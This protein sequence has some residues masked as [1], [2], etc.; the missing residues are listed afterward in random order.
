RN[1][2]PLYEPPPQS[3]Q[4][5]M[6]K[7]MG[8]EAS[9]LEEVICQWTEDLGSLLNQHKSFKAR[10]SGLVASG[11]S[12]GVLKV[13]IG[14]TDGVVDGTL[15]ATLNANAA[16]YA[17]RTAEGSAIATPAAGATLIKLTGLNV[18]SNV[19]IK[20]LRLHLRGV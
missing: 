15:V 6:E 3:V 12:T 7:P 11:A 1:V 4:I 19:E 14:G 13:Y 8:I 18:D 10:L 2:A 5:A 16:A 17:A 20:G 9:G